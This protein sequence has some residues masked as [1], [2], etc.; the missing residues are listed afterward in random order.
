MSD[1]RALRS[2]SDGGCDPEKFGIARVDS[3]G[4]F[5]NLGWMLRGLEHSSV[6][7]DRRSD[8]IAASK[9][10]DKAFVKIGS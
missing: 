1:E 7:F 9:A 10:G 6:L 4:G 3:E 8:V 2:G 5:R